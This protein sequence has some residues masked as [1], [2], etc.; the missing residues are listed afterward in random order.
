[1]ATRKEIDATQGPLFSQIVLYAIPLMLTTMLQTLFNA[2]DIAVLGNMADTTAVA[3]VG[4]TTNIY[5]LIVNSFVGIS[6]GVKVLLARYVG[7]GEKKKAQESVSTA[8]LCA[9]GLGGFVLLLGYFLASPF[10]TI[11]NCPLDCRDGALLYLRIYL[12][13]APAVLLYNCGISILMAN[14]DSKRPLYYMMISG[15]G[16]LVLNILFCLIL[17]N[18]VVAVAIATLSTQYIG[19]FLAMNRVRD[20]YKLDLKHLIFRRSALVGI[21]RFGIPG[22]ITSI[23]YP[24]SNLQIQTALNGYGSEA[25]AGTSA[26]SS[27]ESLLS[28][29]TS[30]FT[31]A[32]G[33]FM[34]QN[35]GAEKPHRVKKTM[36][37][38]M[39]MEGALGIGMG[40]IIL[41]T[42][43]FWL[44]L[45]LGQGSGVAVGFGKI[46]ILTVVLKYAAA[47]CTGTLSSLITIL[48]YPSLSASLS[49]LCILGI[50]A[51]WMTWIYPL[52]NTFFWL[53]MCQTVSASVLIILYIIVASVLY[54]R[55]KQGIYKK[56]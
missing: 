23:L 28:A 47:A 49:L 24:L 26:A 56:L 54:K 43:N 12:F 20:Y 30:P 33:V 37:I 4:A 44:T 18:K 42:G 21:L 19:A 36:C 8:V 45:I 7:T 35:I 50:R 40:F 27:L 34:N 9:L 17:P 39:F 3:S 31:T 41:L 29:F 52:L 15:A 25:I 14:G 55:Y 11:T 48:G 2:I 6:S 32:A 46:K 5:N 51:I 10:L 1:M 16:N 53:N 22:F 38:T 13:A